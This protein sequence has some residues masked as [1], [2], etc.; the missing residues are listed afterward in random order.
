Q[1]AK[2][3]SYDVQRLS[4]I[5]Q[6]FRLL[7]EEKKNRSIRRG[8]WSTEYMSRCFRGWAKDYLVQ[9]FLSS[10]QQGK[11]AKRILLL[12]DE[13]IKLAALPIT[14]S[15]PTVRKFMHLWKFHKK[16]IGKQVE[17]KI[18]DYNDDE[19]E[20]IIL[21]ERLEIWDSHHVLVTHDEVY[22]YANDDNSF[23]WV[24]NN[25]SFIKKKGQGSAIMNACII[26]KP[27]HQSDGYWK[28]E[29]MIQQ[30]RDK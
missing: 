18:E 30:L 21:P 3:Q 27:G 10:Y 1:I 28:S 6:Y 11:Y 5:C 4:S 19:I 22:F 23:F 24:E 16:T 25:K 2:M 20:I 13:D 12:D 15:E 14:I 8:I 17:K 9:D 7:L 26:I 29:N